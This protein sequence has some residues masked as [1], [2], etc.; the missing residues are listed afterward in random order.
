M[1]AKQK[2]PLSLVEEFTAGLER[3]RKPDP[4]DTE[5]AIRAVAT[6]STLPNLRA[7]WTGYL[8]QA[9][10]DNPNFFNS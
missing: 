10:T 7:Y 8:C 3:G 2:K 4:A 6:K 5:K 9:S 1:P